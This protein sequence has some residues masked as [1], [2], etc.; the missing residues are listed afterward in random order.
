ME[1][2]F[3]QGNPLMVDY[4]PSGADVDPGD[5]V[6]I[7]AI[8]CV[9]HNKIADGTLGAL[10]AHGGVYEGSGEAN[11]A[12]GEEV[13]WDDATNKFADTNTA[14]TDSVHFGYVAPGQSAGSGGG[15]VRVIHL[16]NGTSN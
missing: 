13:F 6:V 9:A 16:P 12:E 8:P 2:T 10:A 4:T 1:A 5:V 11:L 3:I 15:T 7:G 14:A